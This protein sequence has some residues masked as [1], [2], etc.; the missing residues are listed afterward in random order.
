MRSFLRLCNVYLCL[1]HPWAQCY[2]SWL[3]KRSHDSVCVRVCVRADVYVFVCVCK[4]TC[5]CS[6]VCASRRVCVRVCVQAD[7]YVF[8]CVCKQTCMC[9]CV[10]A[11]RRVCVCVCVQADV[12]V[13]VCGGGGG[14]PLTLTLV[15]LYR[16]GRRLSRRSAMRTG[17]LWAA[18]LNATR[19][20]RLTL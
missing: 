3:H 13:C 8:V 20:T 17:L 1:S 9:S 11:S 16:M 10:C 15:S 4:Q 12:H 18:E 2:P 6:C 7:V 5:M 14:V 19:A